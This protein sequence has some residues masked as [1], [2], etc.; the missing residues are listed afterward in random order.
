MLVTTRDGDELVHELVW[1]YVT[2]L[3]SHWI[4]AGVFSGG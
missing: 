2:R 3:C 4:L 1:V